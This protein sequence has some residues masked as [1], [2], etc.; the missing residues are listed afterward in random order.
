M[1]ESV[2]LGTSKAFALGINPTVTLV[3][4]ASHDH[5]ITSTFKHRLETYNDLISGCDVVLMQ[6]GLSRALTNPSRSEARYCCPVL[7]PLG[8]KPLIR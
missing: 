7:A 5:S 4:Q 2:A 6:L 8:L 3:L 1:A